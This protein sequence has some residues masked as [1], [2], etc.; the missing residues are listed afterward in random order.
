MEA[1]YVQQNGEA[2]LPAIA[3]SAMNKYYSYFTGSL[4]RELTRMVIVK[5]LLMVVI[6]VCFVCILLLAHYL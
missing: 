1:F 3:I 5:A 4:Q 2:L 6:V